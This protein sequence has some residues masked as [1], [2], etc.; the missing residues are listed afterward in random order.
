MAARICTLSTDPSCPLPP[1]TSAPYINTDPTNTSINFTNVSPL[2]SL[3][4]TLHFFS[5]SLSALAQAFTLSSAILRL[6][7]CSLIDR[8]ITGWHPIG[9]HVP[10]PLPPTP[11]TN[12]TNTGVV[13]GFGVISSDYVYTLQSTYC[14]CSG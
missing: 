13:D 2:T 1:H 9:L 3:T 14:L 6:P 4:V 10:T 7:N 11:T 5:H 8:A 12:Y